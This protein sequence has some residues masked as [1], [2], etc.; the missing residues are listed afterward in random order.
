MRYRRERETRETYLARKRAGDPRFDASDLAEGF[1]PYFTSGERVK[2]VNVADGSAPRFGT[3]GITTG[4]KPAFLL[5][6]RSNA[7][8]SSDLLGP[9]D[10][11]IAVESGSRYRALTVSA[12]YMNPTVEG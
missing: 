4:W 9:N 11:V 3:V 7:V 6:H 2:V 10:R 1:W 5:M 8:G 12:E